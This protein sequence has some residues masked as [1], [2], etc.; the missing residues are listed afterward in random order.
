MARPVH[1]RIG[2]TTIAALEH[3]PPMKTLVFM[4]LD[5]RWNIEDRGRAM[6]VEPDIGTEEK[7]I[8]TR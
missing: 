4:R 7:K 6:V 8:I 2:W 3:P 5:G 1:S